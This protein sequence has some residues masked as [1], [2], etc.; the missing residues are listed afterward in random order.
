MS[1]PHASPVTGASNGTSR[2]RVA[3]V[4]KEL[5]A[6]VVVRDRR[7]G[8]TLLRDCFVASEA[9]DV[10]LARAVASS[11]AQAAEW[12]QLLL[13]KGLIEEAVPVDGTFEDKWTFY[14]LSARG[15]TLQKTPLSRRDASG[16]VPLLSVPAVLSSPPSSVSHSPAP[17]VSPPATLS[18]SEDA[19][20][21]QELVEAMQQR[22]P[23]TPT[24]R[25]GGIA[26]NIPGSIN[27]HSLAVSRGDRSAP[28]LLHHMRGDDGGSSPSS[29]KGSVMVDDMPPPME[30][31]LEMESNSQTGRWKRRYMVLRDGATQWYR[32]EHSGPTGAAVRFCLLFICSSW[33]IC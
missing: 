21:L 24:R 1:S 26:Q 14:R 5:C 31:W 33:L 27:R 22:S 10:L 2:R 8:D 23:R 30:G 20:A 25:G 11:R 17:S 6:G 12:G 29:R 15:R 32:D 18:A 16:A 4:F 19:D 3:Q 13:D 7:V 28:E 9:V